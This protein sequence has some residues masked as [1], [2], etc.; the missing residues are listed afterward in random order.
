MKKMFVLFLT[1]ILMTVQVQASTHD[2]LK[3]AIDELTYSLNVEWDQKDQSF[4]DQKMD[5]FKAKL[6]SYKA[7]GMT[8]ADLLNFIMS[9]TKNESLRKNIDLAFTQIAINKLSEK[10]SLELIQ[11]ANKKSY[12][13][14]AS[15]SVNWHTVGMVAIGLL[16][17]GWVIGFASCISDQNSTVTSSES[18]SC[19]SDDC[20]Y[21]ATVGCSAN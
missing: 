3:T 1:L 19:Y 11:D 7:N 4:Y 18:V 8:N 21:S 9:E 12:Q 2:G 5:A 15:W 16:L 13:Q 10:Q 6:A 17:V 20:Y 14:G